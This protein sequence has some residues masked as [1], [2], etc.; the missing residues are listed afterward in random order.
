MEEMTAFRRNTERAIERYRR[1]GFELGFE[2]GFE[3][4]F[5]LGI[6]RG[7]ERRIERGFERGFEHERSLL[8]RQASRRF[9]D[10][11]RAA[12]RRM[13]CGRE[14]PG[15]VRQGGRSHRGL[16]HRR[17]VFCTASTGRRPGT[18]R[19]SFREKSP[20]ARCAGAGSTGR[21]IGTPEKTRRAEE[22]MEEMTAF[23]RNTER[24]IERYRREGIERGFEHERSLLA[25]SGVHGG[26]ATPPGGGSAHG[27]RA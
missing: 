25:A 22:L 24:A 17:G 13:A 14:R 21:R 12:A 1:E 2:R 27:L 9:G 7:L 18:F 4:G 10:G 15:R 26:S 11:R 19:L 23:R 3:L 20:L 5:K 6:E 16:R 8:A